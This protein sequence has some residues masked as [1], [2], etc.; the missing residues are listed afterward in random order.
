M[1]ATLIR[2]VFSDSRFSYF[3]VASADTVQ[4]HCSHKSK[5]LQKSAFNISNPQHIQRIGLKSS[6]LFLAP[7]M[8]VCFSSMFVYLSVGLL[9]NC[10]TDSHRTWKRE[11]NRPKRET[12]KW[13]HGARWVSGMLFLYISLI[14]HDEAFLF[15]IFNLQNKLFPFKTD[16]NNVTLLNLKVKHDILLKNN[17]F[18][19]INVIICE[20]QVKDK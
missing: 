18:E 2:L 13:W 8:E 10:W 4:T 17:C 6:N 3:R 20:L 7:T 15:N 12:V 16:T 19:Y 14:W 1:F 9:R 5:Y 11:R